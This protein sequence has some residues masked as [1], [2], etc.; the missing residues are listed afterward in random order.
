MRKIIILSLVWAT[1][2]AHSSACKSA[3]VD[4]LAEDAGEISTVASDVTQEKKTVESTVESRINTKATGKKMHK[5][6][7]RYKK[8]EE[9]VLSLVGQM[10][11]DRAYFPFIRQ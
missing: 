6:L 4:N 8:G 2:L 1:L 3:S 9:N 11:L 7:D 5:K 10:M